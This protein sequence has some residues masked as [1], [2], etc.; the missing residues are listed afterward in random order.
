MELIKFANVKALFGSRFQR[1]NEKRK[2]CA[3]EE[4][5]GNYRRRSPPHVPRPYRVAPGSKNVADTVF[6]KESL[7]RSKGRLLE[8]FRNS[9]FNA[10][11]CTSAHS[12]P[13]EVS[14]YSVPVFDRNGLQSIAKYSVW[15]SIS[16][17]S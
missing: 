17:K 1:R 6:A 8:T 16:V 3:N 14:R 13:L 9:F 4:L 10:A 12:E 7:L 5:V 11:L 15:D 2:A